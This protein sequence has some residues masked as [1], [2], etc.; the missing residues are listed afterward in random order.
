MT[1]KYKS[2]DANIFIEA[3][4]RSGQKSLNCQ[5][6]L[7]TKKLKLS[8]VLLSEIIYVTTK[9]YK[10]DRKEACALIKSILKRD[11]ILIS[12]KQVLSDA[13]SLFSNHKLDWADCYLLAQY[14]AGK[15]SGI[16]S[17]D[18]DLDKISK[19]ARIEP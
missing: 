14:T 9:T 6:L 4:F 1:T 19:K 18:T 2:V 5:K 8:I 10:I 11:N 15:T 7:L 16:Y 3:F 13:L 17:Y 12:K